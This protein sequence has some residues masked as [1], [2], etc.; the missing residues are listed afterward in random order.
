MGNFG[1]CSKHRKASEFSKGDRVRIVCVGGRAF[2]G[3]CK[4][5]SE[6]GEVIGIYSRKTGFGIYEDTALNGGVIDVG[7]CKEGCGGHYFVPRA[8][9]KV[10]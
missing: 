6:I 3:L 1:K 5:L 10:G 9:E 8:L 7:F 4:H 2:S